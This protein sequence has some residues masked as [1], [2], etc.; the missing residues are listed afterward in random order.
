[1][2]KWHY[3]LAKEFKKR[4]NPKD[5][6]PSE[7]IV[8][9]LS[10]IVLTVL[11][12][13]IKLTEDKNLIISEWFKFRWD[14]DKTFALSQDVPNLLDDAKNYCDEATTNV[15]SYLSSAQ[16]SCASATSVTETH[17]YGGAPCQM[18]TA[19]AALSA[20]IASVSNAVTEVKADL[21][22]AVSKVSEAIT[23]NKTE[24]LQLK[25]NLQI[26]DKVIIVP[27]S[28]ADIFFLI[29]KVL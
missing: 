29:D 2:D 19:V 11:D 27:S 12:S 24:L 7:A 28:Q 25:L 3:N 22:A 14:I 1:L 13:K 4:D 8:V 5:F 20:A 18:P 10:P 17:S 23:K 6:K 9:S 16:S 26:D 21:S 15:Q